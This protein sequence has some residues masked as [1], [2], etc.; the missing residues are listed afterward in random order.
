MPVV[1]L[2]VEEAGVE[3]SAEGGVVVEVEEDVE[4]RFEGGRVVG[5]GTLGDM[6]VAGKGR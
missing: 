2:G 5:R 1:R 3:E 6:G 4:D